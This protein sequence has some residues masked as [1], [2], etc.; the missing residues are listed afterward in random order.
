MSLCRPRALRGVAWCAPSNYT[1]RRSVVM[2]TSRNNQNVVFPRISK[3][4]CGE[5]VVEFVS[6]LS[7]I[8][9]VLAWASTSIS[10]SSIPRT[11]CSNSVSIIH[12]LTGRETERI[13]HEPTET[14]QRHSLNPLVA[15]EWIAEQV[16]LQCK[17]LNAQWWCSIWTRTTAAQKHKPGFTFKLGTLF[18]WSLTTSGFY[19][20]FHQVSNWNQLG[21][22]SCT[23]PSCRQPRPAPGRNRLATL[24]ATEHNRDYQGW[25][26]TAK[27]VPTPKKEKKKESSN[28]DN[29]EDEKTSLWTASTFRK[30]L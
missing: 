25:Q 11:T 3:N 18:F 19:L 2:S 23:L 6:W 24:A 14:I 16:L 29:L 12:C 21:T 20:A 10:M 8:A 27:Q 17:M 7:K 28:S 5:E 15:W 26:Q 4:I 1:S 22:V 9:N 30:I 13:R